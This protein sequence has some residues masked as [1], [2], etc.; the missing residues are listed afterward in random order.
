MLLKLNIK[1]LSQLNGD[2]IEKNAI[3][4]CHVNRLFV[5]HSLWYLK[6]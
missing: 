2:K 1:I 5:K 6:F 3:K 4:E